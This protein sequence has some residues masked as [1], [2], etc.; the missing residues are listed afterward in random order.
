MNHKSRKKSKKF[1][2][3]EC[4]MFC[5]LYVLYGGL[6]IGKLELLI[7]NLFFSAVHFSIFGHQKTLDPDR[8]PA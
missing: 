4:W 1:H 5:N 3:L 8:Y 2:V 7:K 6:G